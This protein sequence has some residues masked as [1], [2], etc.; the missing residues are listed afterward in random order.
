MA[1]PKYQ[2]FISSTY[3]DLKEERDQVI[4][5]ILEMG[6]I[7]VGMEM[8]SAADEDQW[9]IIKR[10]I[11]D[12]DYY[13]VIVAHR[14][15]SVVDGI[16]FTEKEY[17]YAVSQGI[18]VLGFVIKESAPWP[19]DRMEKGPKSLKALEAF[20]KKVMDKPVDFWSTKDDLHSSSMT[21]LVKQMARTPRTGWVRADQATDPQVASELARLSA[22]NKKLREGTS[23]PV[24]VA[25]EGLDRHGIEGSS[26]G[27]VEAFALY[28]LRN[29]RLDTVPANLFKELD[30]YEKDV[31]TFWF[32]LGLVEREVRGSEHEDFRTFTFVT[33]LGEQVLC[34]LAATGILDDYLIH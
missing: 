25:I 3:E 21:A 15:G 23:D 17:D 31:F 9:E 26:F 24:Q 16:S 18:P 4:K 14:Y 2:I 7:P 6:H 11:D 27:P 1:N 28:A 5:A 30:D 10:T 20:K 13:V 12:T 8:F 34:R 22:E 19:R 29:K 32:A 33:E